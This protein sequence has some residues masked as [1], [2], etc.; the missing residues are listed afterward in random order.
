M[1]V[2]LIIK[3]LMRQ[4]KKLK[5][6]PTS[7]NILLPFIYQSAYSSLICISKEDFKERKRD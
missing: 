7:K 4:K 6:F 3:L 2:Q 5:V 1:N